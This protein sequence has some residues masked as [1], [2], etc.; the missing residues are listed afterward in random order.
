MEYDYYVS[1]QKFP[2]LWI[3]YQKLNIPALS[4]SDFNV[5]IEHPI[6]YV[7]GINQLPMSN[8][9]P[10]LLYPNPTQ[11]ILNIQMNDNDKYTLNIYSID[12]KLM[13][14]TSVQDKTTVQCKE[15]ENGIYL[16]NLI[17]STIPEKNKSLKF[18][19]N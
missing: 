5:E 17:N 7:L 13:Y 14:S 2:V 4:V 12:G 19:K 6:N 9:N 8:N 1:G 18:L 3:Q 10:V 15:W 16:I 11:H